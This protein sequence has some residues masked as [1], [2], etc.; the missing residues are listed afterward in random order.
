LGLFQT[1]LEGLLVQLARLLEGTI[2][3]WLLWE[4][5]LGDLEKLLVLV[6]GELEVSHPHVN[7][8]LHLEDVLLIGGLLESN[9]E[10]V[11]GFLDFWLELG[12]LDSFLGVLF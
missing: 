10:G 7:D 4:F 3:L 11:I 12:L 1:L 8:E 9:W 6:A 5:I 2:S